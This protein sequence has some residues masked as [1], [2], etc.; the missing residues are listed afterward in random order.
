M[1]AFFPKKEVQMIV[2][3]PVCEGRGFVDH[4][5]ACCKCHGTGRE[6]ATMMYG[7]A[8]IDCSAC[9]GTGRSS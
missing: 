8:V 3:C 9:H 7:S 6:A 5:N 1:E 2:N 4:P